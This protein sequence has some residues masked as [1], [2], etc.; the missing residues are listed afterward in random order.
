MRPREEWVEL[1]N[2]T[3]ALVST[4]LFN[5]VQ[6]RLRR[7]K[8]LASRNTRRPY[9][10]SGYVFCEKCGRRYTARSRGRNAYYSCP[11]CRDR[12]LNADYI[13][14]SIWFKVEEVLSNP[15]IVY[16]GIEMLQ[17]KVSSEE[18][19]HKELERVES[20]LCHMARE[21]DRLWN[22]YKITGDEFKFTSEIKGIM[23][24]IDELERR[25]TELVNQAQLAEQTETNIDSIREYCELVRHN[26][27]SLSFLNKRQAL[28]ALGIKVIV[29]KEILKLEGTLPI[30]SSQRA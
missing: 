5:L 2:A 11:K 18:Q 20:E 7:N 26:L 10:L 4:D 12:N 30:M 16:A 25:K 27:G 1:Q 6:S 8:E 28:E 3:P 17:D 19:Y 13:E 15:D 24:E 29:R 21:K 9:L 14:P 23:L 22:A